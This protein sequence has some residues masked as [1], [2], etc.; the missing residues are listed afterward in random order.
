M[1]ARPQVLVEPA[2]PFAFDPNEFSE[3]IEDLS[4]ELGSEYSVRVAYREQVGAAVTLYEVINI[5]LSWQNWSTAAQGAVAG[6][7]L[8]KVLNWRKKRREANLDTPPRPI[9]IKVIAEK[10]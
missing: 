6:V 1:N 2:N 4:E 8:E 3:M 10:V 5:W 9:W 7:L